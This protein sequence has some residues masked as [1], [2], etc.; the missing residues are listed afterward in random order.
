MTSPGRSEQLALFGGT[1]RQTRRVSGSAPSLNKW[2]Y[3]RREALE[4]CPRKYHYRYYGSSLRTAKVEPHEERLRFLKELGNRHLRVGQIAHL[5]IRTY[6]LH[7]QRG[8]EWS[9]DRLL[10]F[11]RAIYRGDVEHSRRYRPGDPLPQGNRAPVLLLEFYYGFADAEELW[12]E[13]EARL[14]EAL[15][16]F[17]TSPEI[18]CFRFGGSQP[19][20]LV[21]DNVN[22]KEKH[23]SLKG[24]IDLSYVANGRVVLIDWKVGDARGGDESLQLF[25]Y[26]LDA[27]RRHGCTL[28]DLDLYRVGLA[29]NQVLPFPMGEREMARAR[30]HIIQ[31][32]ER[33]RALDR[34]GRDAVCE[35]FTPCGQPRICAL[36]PF[37][38]LCP[39]G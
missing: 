31:D 18:K 14:I 3:S 15:N 7:R 26:A 4:Q 35:A 36:C 39:K 5:V 11:A 19:D 21:E 9:L 27:I 2:S 25:S 33:M 30:A 20:A 8:E 34:Y 28:D 29:D 10:D 37:Q 16:T 17:A 12:A 1:D 23:F 13:S 38:E 6:L 24:Q 22:L 32:L